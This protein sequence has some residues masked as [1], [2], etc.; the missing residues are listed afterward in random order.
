MFLTSLEIGLVYICISALLSDLNSF[1]WKLLCVVQ[2]NCSLTNCS[3][4]GSIEAS[5]HARCCTFSPCCPEQPD[6]RSML[7]PLCPSGK[8]SPRATSLASIGRSKSEPCTVRP[9]E[10]RLADA[11]V[12]ARLRPPPPNMPPY[13]KSKAVSN[14]FAIS[15]K[16]PKQ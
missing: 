7:E 8:L 1:S 11:Q 12:I 4:S 3:S 10:A 2:A 14:L 16:S 9:S 5:I 6:R 15:R 13:V